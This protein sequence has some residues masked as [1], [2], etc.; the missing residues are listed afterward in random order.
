M[1]LEFRV[2]N[3]RSI[4]AEQRLNLVANRDK[5]RADANCSPTGLVGVPMA[6]RSAAIYGPNASGKSNVVRALGFFQD[7]VKRSALGMTEGQA[8]DFEPFRFTPA[9]PELLTE[10]ELTF[11]EEGVRYQYGFNLDRQR[12]HE[13]WL[14][15]YKNR[16][17]QRWFQRALDPSTNKEEYELSSHLAGERKLWQRSTRANALFLSTA[18]QL[19]SEQLRPIFQWIVERLTIL[20]R[21][22]P[23]STIELIE[24]EAGKTAV[25]ELLNEADLGIKNAHVRKL[26]IA[27]EI[28]RRIEGLIPPELREGWRPESIRVELEHQAQ[29]TTGERISASLPLEEE[30]LGTFRAF[31]LAAPILEALQAG[32][33][34]VID[35]IDRSLHPLLTR[36]LVSKFHEHNV[37]G[38]QL[39][40]TT[41]TTSLL[42]Q[43]WLRRDQI[44]L[45]D[46]D[47]NLATRIYPLTDIRVRKN[48][49]L[50]Q[51]YLHG[52]LGATPVV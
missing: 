29:S 34:L 10:M 43:D 18:V 39:I 21:T 41:H 47:P 12:I 5:T 7:V 1:L 6:I 36:H 24:S 8:F 19:N 14:L 40:F 23:A 33:V 44:F 49:P 38:A 13:E 51:I 11:V 45:V 37:S 25:L 2:S 3:F 46:K 9:G 48:A 22:S 28:L 20:T 42:D 30:S 52:R 50:E 16:K 15:V 17:P 26:P 27:E 31:S 32:K 35:E 4:L